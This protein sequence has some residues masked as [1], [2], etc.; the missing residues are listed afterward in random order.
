MLSGVLR[1]K[2]YTVET[3]GTG[4]E[5]IRLAG[6]VPFDLIIT[7]IFMPEKEGTEFIMD[8]SEEFPGTKVIVMSGGGNIEGVDFLDLARNLGAL[9][10]FKKPFGRE[11]LLTAVDELLA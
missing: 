11:E 6:E 8:I 7:D 5:A 3:A 1:D 9:R 2:G 10:S 4:S